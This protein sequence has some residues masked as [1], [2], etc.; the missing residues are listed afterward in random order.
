MKNVTEED[1]GTLVQ[2]FKA[3]DYRGKRLRL[4]GWLR[5]RE[6]AGGASLWMRV[7]SADK[8]LTFDNMDKRRLKGD[9]DWAKFEIVLD[10][11]EAAQH[12]AFGVLVAGKGKLWV[13]DL[14][15]DVVGNDVKSTNILEQEIPIKKGEF[16]APAK[17]QNLDFEE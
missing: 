4:T 3:D 1:F 6:V 9:S 8:T 17:P 7:D 5:T 2:T 15:F 13:D 12:I 10:V 14:A 16:E 11:P